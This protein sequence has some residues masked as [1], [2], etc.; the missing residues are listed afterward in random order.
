MQE[1]EK[2][3]KKKTNQFCVSDESFKFVSESFPTM[4]TACTY[5]CGRHFYFI[6]NKFA[7]VL[8]YLMFCI[9]FYAYIML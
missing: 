1:L 5:I 4:T 7:V 8:V 3:R 2:L 6:S 9:T